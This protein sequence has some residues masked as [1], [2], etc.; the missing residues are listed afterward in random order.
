[1]ILEDFQKLV[2]ERNIYTPTSKEK[3]KGYYYSIFDLTSEVIGLE[4]MLEYYATNQEGIIEKLGKVISSSV[5]LLKELNF[6]ISTEEFSLEQYKNEIKFNRPTEGVFDFRYF[7]YPMRFNV[8]KLSEIIKFSISDNKQE[9]NNKNK[10]DMLNIIYF[11]IVNTFSLIDYLGFNID[12]VLEK[13]INNLPVHK[14][15]NGK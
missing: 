7:I 14:K 2:F 10:M 4:E 1:M 15:E 3:F 8:A 9:L 6:P 12:I 5:S 11:I 13:H